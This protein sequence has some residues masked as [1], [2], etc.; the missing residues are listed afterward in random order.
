MTSS[1]WQHLLRGHYQLCLEQLEIDADAS[2]L[3]LHVHSLQTSVQCPLCGILSQR[4]HSHY[5]RCIADLTCIQLSVKLI[6]QVRKFFCDNQAC[7]RRIFAERLPG[8]AAPW[9]RKTCRLVKYLQAMGLAL[10]G[11]AGARLAK[12]LGY[13]I[14]G[15]TLLNQLRRLSI[16]LFAVPKRLGVDDFALRRGHRYGTILVDLGCHQPIALLADRQADTI[17]DWLTQHPGVEVL[18]RDRSPT[19]KKGMTQ[20]APAAVQVADRFHLVRNLGDM[21]E[22]LLSHYRP[23]LK[24][25]EAKHRQALVRQRP[26]AVVVQ[27]QPTATE[28]AEAKAQAA[29]RR[30]VKQQREVKRLQ[31]QQWSQS[32]MAATIGISV[33]TVQRFLHQ[34]DFPDTVPRRQVFGRSQILDRYKPM[35]LDWW[36]DGCHDS[37]LLLHLL[38]RQGYTGGLRTLQRYLQQVRAAQ[39]I[40]P[41]QAPSS[42]FQPALDPQ[43]PPFTARR[44][45]WLILQH[46]T[47]RDEHGTQQ[48]A[49]LQA[50]HPDLAL[51]VRLADTFL[52]L[53]RQ[54]QGQTFDTWLTQ[55]LRSPLKP[56]QKFASSLLEDYAAVKM[57]M[58]TDISN[59]PVEGLNNRL[60]MLK[61]QMYGRANLE[62]LERRFILT[63]RSY[64]N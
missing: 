39:G 7:R 8:I 13:A 14:C 58:M 3:D 41:K 27:A 48:L 50:E 40:R 52:Q 62:L 30:R 56:F 55:A 1:F 21:L 61:R 23:Q 37:Q 19:Y 22:T 38:Q 44:A 31:A 20:G 34:P 35:L 10:G 11:I 64:Q 28:E 18:S 57:S 49:L 47:H 6:V 32:A 51:T 26:A 25:I 54:Q 43:L 46:P 53:L 42:Q 60:K 33:R 17:A 16:P 9:A 59:G 12:Q 4:I 29:H 36:N 45:A 63:S 15:S 24:S 5:E 2:H